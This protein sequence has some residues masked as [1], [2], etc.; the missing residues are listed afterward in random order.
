MAV[1]RGIDVVPGPLA[2][3]PDVGGDLQ[4]AGIV[5]RAGADHDEPRV[6]VAVAVDR[7]A[8]VGAEV[9]AQRAAALRGGIVVALGR[10]LGDLEAVAGDDGIDGAAAPRSPLA[11]CAMASAPRG[12]GGAHGVADG[13]A[14]AASGE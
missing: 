1:G 7:R 5:E 6:R 11:V 10:P 2:G 14:E 9:A 3:G 13:S 8:A 4:A 12:D